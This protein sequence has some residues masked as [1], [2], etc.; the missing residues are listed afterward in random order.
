MRHG[1]WVLRFERVSTAVQLSRGDD[2]GGATV[3]AAARIMATAA[4]NG[5]VVS[6]S[7]VHQA[8]DAFHVGPPAMVTLRGF[9]DP[10]TLHSVLPDAGRATGEER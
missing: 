1:Q 8:G 4:A 9:P 3:H 10:M 5:V 2:I 7:V 6:D